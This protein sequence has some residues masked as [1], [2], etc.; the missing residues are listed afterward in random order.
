MNLTGLCGLAVIEELDLYYVKSGIY[1]G[2]ADDGLIMMNDPN[3]VKDF[4]QKLEQSDSGVMIKPS[5]SGRVRFE[6]ENTKDLIFTGIG[7]DGNYLKA[8][9]RTRKAWKTEYIGPQ[10]EI[11]KI[12]IV[13][14][15]DVAVVQDRTEMLKTLENLKGIADKKET[16]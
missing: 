6:G 11:P 8:S 9:T 1:I 15:S 3:D 16:D 4:L 7:F 2:Y 14:D 12:S 13:K 5:K 10:T